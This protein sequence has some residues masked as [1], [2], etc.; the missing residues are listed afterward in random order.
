MKKLVC[1]MCGS[2]DL[3]KKDGV[4]ECQSCGTKYTVEEAKK[5]M[6]DGIVNVEGTV[7]IDNSNRIDN[8]IKNGKTLYK[9]SKFD[10]AYSLFSEVLNIDS[11]NY[12][13]IAYKGLCSAWKTSIKKPSLIGDAIKG[14]DRSLELAIDTLGDTEEYSDY[15]FEI[16]MEIFDICKASI[17]LYLD[18]FKDNSSEFQKNSEIVI[19]AMKK[20]NLNNIAT[21]FS[22]GYISSNNDYYSRQFDIL[23]DGYDEAEK[24]S[25]TG[26]KITFAALS[27]TYINVA[28]AMENFATIEQ[29]KIIK[30]N[31]DECINKIDG[32]VFPSFKKEYCDVVAA[33]RLCDGKIKEIS[34][35][36][37]DK[38]WKEHKEEKKKFEEEIEEYK[39]EI[40]SKIQKIAD[41]TKEK[42]EIDKKINSSIP[43]EKE[44]K[45]LNSKKEKLEEEKA[46]LGLF[47]VKKK[48]VLEE[49][50]DNVEEQIKKINKKAESERK[51][52]EKKYQPDIAK[53][54]TKIEKE[55]KEIDKL[56]NKI[57]KINQELDR[58]ISD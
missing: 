19:S 24:N 17:K 53:V 22:G 13:A 34:Q 35:Q 11:N 57:L 43:L 30:S 36:K 31:L 2:N 44:L 15:A 7:K 54:D 4:F 29:Y 6:V 9:D 40:K 32:Y 38:Y 23:K 27:I 46:S 18:Y 37:K 48:R 16:S 3:L 20:E 49:E 33:S 10:E 42:K 55:E 25:S 51:N 12:I 28:T 56:K 45:I 26:L 1:E 58:E 5:M 50:L 41:L 47:N 39:K 8:L 14:F 52:L 21:A